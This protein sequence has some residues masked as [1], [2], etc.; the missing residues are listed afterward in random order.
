MSNA[1]R[2]YLRLGAL[3][4]HFERDG[5][6]IRVM[7][8]HSDAFLQRGSSKVEPSSQHCIVLVGTP[9]SRAPCSME[10]ALLIDQERVPL[11]RA[12]TANQLGPRHLESGAPDDLGR[13]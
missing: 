1:V 3:P 2:M 7:K 9:L 5:V 12:A 4:Q 13:R 10:R 8:K 11:S 6:R